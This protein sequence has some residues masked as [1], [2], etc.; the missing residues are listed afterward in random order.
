[1]C[2]GNIHA[3]TEG[4]PSA[5]VADTA[6]PNSETGVLKV[7]SFNLDL[8][9]SDQV[10]IDGIFHGPTSFSL[11]LPR[12][13]HTVRVEHDGY[14]PYVEKFVLG[15]QETVWAWLKPINE[16]GKRTTTDEMLELEVWKYVKDS[17]DPELIE[18]YLRQ[19]PNGRFSFLAEKKLKAM[20]GN[21]STISD[22]SIL[23]INYG[24]YYAL[25]IG[26][27]QYKHFSDLRTAVNDARAVAHTLESN[28]GFNVTLLTNTTRSIILGSIKNLRHQVS[29]DDNVLVYY[30]GHGL[31]HPDTD[32]GFWL[33]VD[34]DQQDESN[35]LLTDRV[36]SQIKVMSAKHVL[37]VADSCFSGKFTRSATRGVTID[38]G[39][40]NYVP[41][42]KRLS[43]KRSRT[44]LTSGGLEPVL[45]SI[46]NSKHSVF[47]KV[48]L[49]LLNANERVLDAASLSHK[50]RSKVI[51]Y[52]SQTPEYGPIYEAG[53]D[54]GDF[55]FV[56]R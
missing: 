27:N 45:D 20:R 23:N 17:D 56:R 26:N 37:V 51:S 11:E 39:A 24:N 7:L 8:S 40:T 53:H 5:V 9:G 6:E 13:E 12:G 32:E 18:E 29:S 41:T 35:W 36:R 19:F 47:A 43:A 31:V 52:S 46:G 33:P 16:E 10:Y 21:G 4:A 30:A 28:Y 34:A 50:L 44:V 25:V 55:L 49:S 48:F 14:E 1:M 2:G 22:P 15:K 42:L 54:G 3:Q 38:P